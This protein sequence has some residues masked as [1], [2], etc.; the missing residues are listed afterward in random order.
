MIQQFPIFV[1]L[2]V[3][4]PLTIGDAPALAAKLR[5]LRKAAPLAD[6]FAS[7]KT[8]WRS[9]FATDTGVCLLGG[10]DQPAAQH[11]LAG[12]P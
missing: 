5:L 6:V 10:M 1:D 4:P 9:E 3:M 8:E 12:H 2:H 11:V 7:A